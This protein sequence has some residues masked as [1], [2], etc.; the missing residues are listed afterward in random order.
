MTIPRKMKAAILHELNCPLVIDEVGLPEKLETGQVLVEVRYTGICGSQ[1]GE[2]RGVKGEDRYLP[3]LLGHEG[4]G[5]VLE[6]G[7]GVTRIQSGDRVVMHWRQGAGLA[8]APPKYTWRGKPLNAGFVTTFNQYAI[9]SE[10]RLTPCSDE[11]PMEIAPLMGC[12]VTTGLGVI[13]NNAGLKIGESIV[14]LG[15]GG[16][17]LN[18]I[19]GAQMSSAHPV[20]AV[21]VLDNRLEMAARFGATHLINTTDKEDL[22]GEVHAVTGPAGPDVVIDNTGNTEMISLA[23]KMVANDGRVVLVGVPPKGDLIRIYSLDL[24]FG[25]TIS[26]SHGGE[27][28]PEKDIPRFAALYANGKLKLD[29]LITDR[30]T[31]DEIN[32][33]ITDM[34]TGKT[35]GRCLIDLHPEFGGK[36]QAS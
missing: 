28:R 10:N 8:S 15:A 27:T 31:L 3:H 18:M 20:I 26:G 34:E 2:I 5:I 24:H 9:V 25:K 21:D 6:T 17:G 36:D 12:A 22:V 30:Y 4:A 14:V 32:R 33:A 16:V 1:L 35:M 19:Q 7:P 23:Y 29:E 11:L 13:N